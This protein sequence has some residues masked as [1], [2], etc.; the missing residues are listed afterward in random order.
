MADANKVPVPGKVQKDKNNNKKFKIEKGDQPHE[1]DVEVEIADAGEYEVEK[2]R[3]EGLPTHIDNIQIRWFNNFSIKKKGG[4]YIDQ[5]YK[6]TIPGLAG[7]GS[8]RLVIYN[9]KGVLY[10]YEGTIDGDTFELT[11]G[12]PGAGSAP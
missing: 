3:M 4:G 5:R 8:S 1:V 6:V 12:D 11:D 2:L 9:G 10:Y 7:R